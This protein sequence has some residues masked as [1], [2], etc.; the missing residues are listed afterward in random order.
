MQLSDF[1]GDWTLEREIEDARAARTGTFAGAARF[2]PVGGNLAYEETGTLAFPGTPSMQASRRYLW[3]TGGAGGIDVLFDDGRF[4]HG[5]D[6]AAP[7]PSAGHDCAPD[8]YRVRYDFTAWP[9]WQAEWR[10]T[11]PRKDYSMLSRYRP[12]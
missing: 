8:T 10:V 12:A 6:P 5:F 4:F 11:G 1:A 2:R 7:A 9:H 3:R